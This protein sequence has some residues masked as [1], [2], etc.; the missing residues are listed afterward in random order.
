[1]DPYTG[2]VLAMAV[3][4][5]F[6][7]N[8]FPATKADRRRNRA[9]T[10]TYEP[11]STFK[12]VTVAAGTPGGHRLAR[13]LVPAPADDQGGGSRDPRGAHSRDRA[14]DGSGHRRALV[15]HR[16]DHDRA[17][18]RGG[19]P[20][21]LD[22]Q[23]RVRAADRHRLPGRV[24]GLRAPAR[25]V[26]GVDD[27]HRPDRSR[28]C[29][30]AD[31]D[32][33]RVLG[34]RERRRAGRAPPRRAGRRQACRAQAAGSASCR[35]RSRI[36]CSRCFAASCSRARAPRPQSRATPSP[37][38]RARRPRST[39]RPAVTR[40]RGTSRRSSGSCRPRNRGS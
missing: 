12:L 7:A 33:A 1:M 39:R 13:D 5:G 35:G 25:A 9:V 29:G 26:V 20:R 19:P 18:D 15:E 30:H 31:P 11:G 27:R 40:A 2:A 21:L 37:G 3:A 6:N 22:R 16:H 23:V 4:P 14:D 32:G 8:R 38:R 36:R 34:D 24:S 10:D 28:D 17:A